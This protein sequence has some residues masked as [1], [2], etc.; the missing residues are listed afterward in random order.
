MTRNQSFFFF[1]VV[2]MNVD[3]DVDVVFF[4]VFFPQGHWNNV[5]TGDCWTQVWLSLMS[6]LYSGGLSSSIV[7]MGIWLP[8]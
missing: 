4:F 7:A 3:V 1:V 5:A 2:D 8:E 6:A